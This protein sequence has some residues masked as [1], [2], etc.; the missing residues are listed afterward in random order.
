[1]TTTIT[2]CNDSRWWDTC[3]AVSRRCEDGDVLG[4][5]IGIRKLNARY[6]RAVSMD[7]ARRH[8]RRDANDIDDNLDDDEDDDGGGGG[9]WDTPYL[10]GGTAR[11]GNAGHEHIG[12]T[13]KRCVVRWRVSL[14]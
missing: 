5:E 14:S 9:V 2:A 11:S 1:M 4:E 3:R 6:A 10:D 12:D 13:S 8:V 7:A